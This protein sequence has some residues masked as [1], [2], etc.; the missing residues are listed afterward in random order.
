MPKSITIKNGEV[1]EVLEINSRMVDFYRRETRKSKVTS[2]GMTKFFTNLLK[3]RN[4][5]V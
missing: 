4:Y 3:L 5:I 1:D 2:K